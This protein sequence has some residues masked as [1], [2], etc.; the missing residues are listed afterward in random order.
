LI[1]RLPPWLLLALANLFWAGNWVVGRGVRDLVPPL[2]LT[3]A[4]WWVALLLVLPFAWPHLRTDGKALFA[5]WRDL[6][7][8]GLTGTAGYNACSYIGLQT[9]T[10]T[11]GLLI[12]SF[13][14]MAIV[15]LGWLCQQ[16]RLRPGETAG[17]LA[18][19]SG[20]LW[21][22][23]HGQPATL[24][25]L[26][27]NA[28]DLWI[29]AAVLSWAIYTLRLH[30]RPAAHPLAFLAALA[31]VGAVALTPFAAWE[32]LTGQ[33]LHAEPAAWAAIF[34]TGAFAA[35]LGFVCW[36]QGVAA[37]GPAQAGLTLHLMPVFGI[38][39]A[40]IFLDERPTWHHL[41]GM[42]LIFGGIALASRRAQQR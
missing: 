25:A 16:R 38:A 29:L 26:H 28:G 34:Y 2:T 18:S 9:T 39:L 42:A 20:V 37:V 3:W 4:R 36:N 24:L 8:L 35:L 7:L 27:F 13:I 10:V 41:A 32:W 22:V 12:N 5:G 11:N 6:L 14:P 30:R 23:A 33:R 31:L 17:L 19:T 40:A 1:H 15:L 21:I